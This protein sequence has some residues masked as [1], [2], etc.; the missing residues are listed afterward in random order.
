MQASLRVQIAMAGPDRGVSASGRRNRAID[1]A[2]GFRRLR[3]RCERKVGVADC[4]QAA[5]LGDVNGD[6]AGTNWH[7]LVEFEAETR[8]AVDR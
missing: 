6:V 7:W 4:V 2:C 1:C 3:Y 8:S 5:E